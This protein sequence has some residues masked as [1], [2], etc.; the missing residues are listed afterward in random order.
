MR[1]QNELILQCHG[2]IVSVRRV[3]AEFVGMFVQ[4]GELPIVKH[5]VR[6]EVDTATRESNT[7]KKKG[8]EILRV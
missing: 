6:T 3:S 8:I 5:R 7:Y 4:V 1:A 2:N